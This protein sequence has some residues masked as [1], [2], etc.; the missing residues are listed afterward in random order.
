MGGV[1]D[2][3]KVGE[4]AGNAAVAAVEVSKAVRMR[5]VEAPDVRPAIRRCCNAETHASN[6]EHG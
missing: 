4:V 2:V 1:M 6:R 5:G 3:A